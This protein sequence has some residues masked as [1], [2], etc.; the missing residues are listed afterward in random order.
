MCDVGAVDVRQAG[1][2]WG[3]RGP[4]LEVHTSTLRTWR[5]DFKGDTPVVVKKY[6][7]DFNVSWRFILCK[8]VS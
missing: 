2:S 5:D 7:P 8:D 3:P 4:V 6:F 1:S